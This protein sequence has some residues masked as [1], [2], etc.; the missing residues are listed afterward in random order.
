MGPSEGRTMDLILKNGEEEEGMKE[1]PDAFSD[2]V[3]CHPW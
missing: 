3:I 1:G 2:M